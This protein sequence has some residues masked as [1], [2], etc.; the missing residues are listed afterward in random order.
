MFKILEAVLDKYANKIIKNAQALLKS[1]GK[2]ASGNLSRSLDYEVK[3]QDNV[4][5]VEFKGEDYLQYVENGRRPN[6]KQPPVN[7][8]LRWLEIK[9][10]K[11]QKPKTVAFLIARSIG[12]KGI[13]PTHFLSKTIRKEN[14]ALKKDITNAAAQFL[15][16]DIIKSIK[17]NK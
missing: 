1:L 7:K 9:P 12:N 6:S 8:I 17:K 2:N 15:R 13:K 5:E 14:T 4:V 16:Y 10:I 3:S 11:V